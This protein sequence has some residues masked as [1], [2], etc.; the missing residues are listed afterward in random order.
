ME[1]EPTPFLLTTALLLLATLALIAFRYFKPL[2][3]NWPL[4]YYL[5]LV[6]YSK[7]FAG[8]LQPGW[9][10]AAAVTALFLRFEF[11][12]GWITRFFR[13]VELV[14]LGY[15]LW[16]SFGLITGARLY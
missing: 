8:S 6:L 7:G 1:F 11:M 14:I 5:L 2:D 13:L 15:V 9:V 3:N 10:Y 4:V 16:R 12:G